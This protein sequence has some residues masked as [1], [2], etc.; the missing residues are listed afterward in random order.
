MKQDVLAA[1]DGREGVD[2]GIEMEFYER[3]IIL[4]LAYQICEVNR[5]VV[6]KT[7]P[8]CH[9]CGVEEVL[10]IDESSDSFNLGFCHL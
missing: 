5:V 2:A 4:P 10:S 8:E 9:F 1:A 6:R 7:V 3:P